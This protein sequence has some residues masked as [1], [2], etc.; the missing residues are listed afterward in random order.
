[1]EE[2]GRVV[3]RLGIFLGLSLAWLSLLATQALAQYP[4]TQPPP[5]TPPGGPDVAFTGASISLGVIILI[6]LVV[7]G[8]LLL[9]AG[10][11]RKAGAVQ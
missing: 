7:T 1:M 9:V 2:R 10:R 4:P 3:K 8:A 11:R 5:T 6:S